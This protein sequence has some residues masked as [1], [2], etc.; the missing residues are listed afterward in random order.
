MAQPAM[1]ILQ[2]GLGNFGTR[3]VEA[4]VRLGFGER[5]WVVDPDASKWADAVRAGVPEQRLLRSPGQALARVQIVDVVTPTDSHHA[6]CRQALDAGK[7]VFVEKPMTRTSAQAR[8]LAELA[9][10]RGRLLQ[11]G[12]SYR[13]H[14]AS[15][16]LRQEIQAGRLGAIRYM[17]GS[18][19]GFKRARTDVGVT[20][21]DGI[22]F[23]DLFNWLL[24]SQPAEVFAVCRDHFNRGLED[25][26]IVLLTYPS[27]AVA[28]VE[29]GYIQPGRWPDTVVPGAM[30]TKELT[31]VGELAVAEVD[32]EAGTLAI[33][34]ARHEPRAGTWAPAIGQ[35]A[36]SEFGACGPVELISRELAAFADAV[37]TR[38]PTLA[39]PIDCGV[40]LAVLMER[41]YESAQLRQRVAVEPALQ[42]RAA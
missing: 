15:L 12:F 36:A 14:P 32:F 5:L 22:H 26:S 7:D 25:F 27:G 33:T 1:D 4:W 11:V 38:Q 41:L 29:S 17:T 37:R 18:F 34:D 6:L 21:T 20:H 3:H 9:D 19:C 24:E 8:E 10:Q 2:I 39:G 28:K 40:H 42:A 31:V 16:R 23:L 35:R 13:F 30:T